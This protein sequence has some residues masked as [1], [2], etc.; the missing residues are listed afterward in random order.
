MAKP[1]IVSEKDIEN[2]FDAY[3]HHDWNTVFNY[4]SDDCVWDASEKRLVGRWNILD[5]W[6]NF[7]AAFKETLGKPENVVFGDHIVYLQLR[8]RLDFLED[9]VFYGKAYKKGAV[10]NFTCVDFYELNDERRII[11]ARVFVKFA[12]P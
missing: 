5:Y 2:F 10:L 8:I 11:S 7:H 1:A 9:G 4:M 6:T 3:N 12:N